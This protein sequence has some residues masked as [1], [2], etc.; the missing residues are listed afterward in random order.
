MYIEDTWNP[1]DSTIMHKGQEDGA[2]PG[3][4]L[5]CN[6]KTMILRTSVPTSQWPTFSEGKKTTAWG[7]K[8][9]ST[10]FHVSQ[11]NFI[12]SFIFCSYSSFESKCL[13]L[14]N[15]FLVTGCFLGK[16]WSFKWESLWKGSPFLSLC[17]E[18]EAHRDSKHCMRQLPLAQPLSLPTPGPPPFAPHTT[19]S[20][21]A[22]HLPC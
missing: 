8:V 19:P 17:E 2:D 21:A 18:A 22:A 16:I 9:K 10:G 5:S 4:Q 7:V 11:H 1:I 6:T 12:T 13:C 3:T 20:W 15:H 14:G